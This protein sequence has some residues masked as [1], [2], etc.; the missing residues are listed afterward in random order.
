M[1]SAFLFQVK[2]VYLDEKSFF[3]HS[4]ILFLLIGQL[5]NKCCVGRWFDFKGGIMALYIPC[6]L[7]V[8]LRTASLRV[9]PYIYIKMGCHA[10]YGLPMC[11]KT[12]VDFS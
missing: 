4:S 6:E 12:K 9:K 10:L 2:H 1:I 8:E 7:V 5:F 11:L 3:R